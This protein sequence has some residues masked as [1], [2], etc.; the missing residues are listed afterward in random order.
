MLVRKSISISDQTIGV[1][2]LGNGEVV[3]FHRN[4]VEL[5]AST[6][7]D[8]KQVMDKNEVLKKVKE[9]LAVDLQY[10]IDTDY[11]TGDRQ[12]Q[13]VYQPTTKLRGVN[14]LSGKWLTADGYSADFPG[15]TKIEKI[16]ADSLP[17]KQNGIT[18][19]EAKEIAE[20]LL[21]IK[22]DKVK[23]NIQSI[24]ELENQNGQAVISIQY[25]YEY[26]NGGTGTN[27]EL[28]KNTGEIIQYSDIKS[29]M[30]EQIE[31][32]PGK[33][34]TLS[35]K[36]ALTQAVKYIKEWAPSKDT[37]LCYAYR[38]TTF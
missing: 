8:L 18:L 33:E 22:S 7:D 1:S 14:A 9:N 20:K 12:V 15:K 2:V 19:E 28:D 5:E 24:E 31:D 10:H 25:M 11:R 13:L 37:S 32:K 36:E 27:L 34:K 29:G 16:S 35:Q 3:S 4:P 38:G 26:A 30:L 17:A 21:D 23:L 6:F